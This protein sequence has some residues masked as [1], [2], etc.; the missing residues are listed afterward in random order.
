MA[1]C[2]HICTY[3]DTYRYI[4]IDTDQGI[5]SHMYMSLRVCVCVYNSYTIYITIYKNIYC[6]L[7]LRILVICIMGLMVLRTLHPFSSNY[8]LCFFS[9]ST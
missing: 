5:Y 6:I 7:Q 3:G 9:L 1:V 2:L 8:H 4:T